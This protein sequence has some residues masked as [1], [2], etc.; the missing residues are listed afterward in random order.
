MCGDPVILCVIHCLATPVLLVLL[1]SLA[2]LPI[3][4]E[5]FHLLLVFLVIP[6]S[7]TALFLGCRLHRR[8]S[9]L[10]WGLSGV[11]VLVLA[12]LVGHDLLGETG[13]KLMTV[14]GALMVA[15][16]HGLNYRLCRS[17]DCAH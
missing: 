17:R 11:G 13:E 6:T 16:S 14:V 9:V 1:P 2:V 3:A 4:D 7:V 8:W 5:S 10:S 15:T 12:A